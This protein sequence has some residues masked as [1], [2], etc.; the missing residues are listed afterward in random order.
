M[1]LKRDQICP[2]CS[3]ALIIRITTVQEHGGMIFPSPLRVAFLGPLDT[4]GIGSFE[5]FI[6]KA[7]G[8]TEWYAHGFEHL[9]ADAEEGIQIID[10]R[11]PSAPV[12]A[13]I[14]RRTRTG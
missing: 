11:P 3:G 4:H 2:A 8:F 1:T 10:A 7:C 9:K 13:L 5:T 12:P 6:C 14:A